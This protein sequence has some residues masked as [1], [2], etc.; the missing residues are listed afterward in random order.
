MKLRLPV[1]LKLAVLAGLRSAAQ[2]TLA[3]GFLAVG[4]VFFSFSAQAE[5][6]P[7]AVAVED[8]DETAVLLDDEASD[9][10]LAGAGVAEAALDDS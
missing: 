4:A 7:L 10:A 9:A 6:D 3:S 1:R 8:E 2:A 5:D